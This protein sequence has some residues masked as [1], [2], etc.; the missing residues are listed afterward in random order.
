MTTRAPENESF[1]F[2]DPLVGVIWQYEKSENILSLLNSKKAWYDLNYLEFLVDWI[3]NVAFLETA[4]EFGLAVWAIILDLPLFTVSQPS[5][6]SY[7]AFGFSPHGMNFENGNF[8]VDAPTINNLSVE[9]KR[10]ILRLRYFQLT[11][12][13]SVPEINE[14]LSVLF[15]PG[16]VFV[17]DNLNMTITYVFT[18]APDSGLMYVLQ[19]FDVLPRPAGVEVDFM[20]SAVDGFGFDPYGLNFDNGNFYNGVPL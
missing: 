18:S 10:L 2:P 8:A 7:P 16:K 17:L 11:T 5:P 4:N 9:Q 3:T 15:G 13:C 12:R 19:Q 20:M 6:P 1:S 14:F